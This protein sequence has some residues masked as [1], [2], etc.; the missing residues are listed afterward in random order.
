MK[1][2]DN[3]LKLHTIAEVCEVLRCSRTTFYH[4]RKNGKI[5]VTQYGDKVLVTQ[6]DLTEFI[7]ES[8]IEKA[9]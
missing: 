5:K 6:D 3:D 4:L 7:K 2:T 9:V 1:T 8:K